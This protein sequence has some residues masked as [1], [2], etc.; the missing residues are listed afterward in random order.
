MK[1]KNAVKIAIS[2]CIVVVLVITAMGTIDYQKTMHNFEK[3]MFAQVV[4]GA[5]DG[6]S[7]NYVGIGY[8]IDIH[9]ELDIE[10]GY[11]IHSAQFSIFGIKVHYIERD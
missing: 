10:Y 1:K 4:N 9:G 2:I 7:G 6:G 11:V 5:D 3:P 8:N